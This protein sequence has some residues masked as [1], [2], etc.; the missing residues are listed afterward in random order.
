MK[1]KHIPSG[2]SLDAC[3][4]YEKLK[5]DG[6]YY[7]GEDCMVMLIKDLREQAMKVISYEKKEMIP[8]TNEE[9]KLYENQKICYIRE[10]E[11]S[12]DKKYSK[13]RDHCRYTG[14]YGRA[15]HSICNSRYKIPK[16]IPVVFHNGS[17][18][19][20]HFIIRQLAK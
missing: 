19:D 15:T 6:K 5:I 17:T 9:K 12:T 3:C 2:Y 20:Y 11:F 4:S 7:R 14:K 13:V 18:Y 8:L 1:A 16:D 10:K